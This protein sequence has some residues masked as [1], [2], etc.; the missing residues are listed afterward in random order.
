[1]ATAITAFVGRTRMGP[2]DTP[3]RIQNLGDFQRTFGG[4]WY[5]SPLTYG[6]QQ[7]F[8]NGGT[9]AVVVRLA[10]EAAAASISMPT[11]VVTYK[12]IPKDNPATTVAAEDK[13]VEGASMAIP[14]SSV[15]H[16]TQLYIGPGQQIFDDQYTFVGP[17]VIL[18]PAGQKFASDKHLTITLP[19]AAALLPEHKTSADIVLLVWDHVSGTI[20]ELPQ[21]GAPTDTTVTVTVTSFSTI[22]P[23]VKGA[24]A[25]PQAGNPAPLVL[26]AKDPGSWSNNLRAIVDY[27]TRNPQDPHLFNLTI[28]LV[29]VI[30]GDPVAN[31]SFLNLS[32]EKS[33]P[34]Y[35][36]A[37]LAG[38]QG[39]QFV[40]VNGPVAG[41][42]LA[43]D[44]QVKYYR[45]DQTGSDGKP[46]QADDFGPA[47]RKAG[48]TGLYALEKTDLFN[49]LCLPPL[50]RYEDATDL[51]P[52]DIP[53]TLWDEADAYCMDRRAMLLVDPPWTW[54]TTADA[55]AGMQSSAPVTVNKNAAIYWPF[56]K[57]PDS[58]ME[59]RISAFAP[60]A[61]V[62]GL[63]ARTDSQRGVWKAP[64]GQ[65]ATILGITGPSAMLT[66]GDSGR[67]NPLGLNCIRSFPVIGPVVWGARTTVGADRLAN[68]WK[69]LPVRRVALFI[70][71]SLYRGMQWAV[72]EP[73]DEPLWTQI[74]SNATGFMQGLFLEGAFQGSMPQQAYFVK[75]DSETNPQINIDRGIVTL[76][77]GFRPLKPAEF[78]VIKIQ[79]LAGQAPG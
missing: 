47:T 21:D 10:R 73:N 17:A 9:D 7:Y 2:L 19:F 62:A 26:T 3:V 50:C 42:P 34:R 37:V 78:V 35:V 70:E 40:R 6:V 51:Q 57:A 59:S 41:R 1:V 18:G 53:K 52:A 27:D 61:A 33:S 79:Q 75:C 49:L 60:A 71:E 54:Q 74:R 4:L 44:A 38:A 64:A 29:D 30:T 58:L 16:D 32:I 46:L 66:D 31:E 28:Q 68:E 65:E 5:D 67:L 25:K 15:D 13:S 23:A 20:K 76:E 55:E 77:I 24:P 63:I 69:Y 45:A 11:G 22:Q 8:L 48:K 12:T 43:N 56:I 36:A 14:A 39:S 72:F